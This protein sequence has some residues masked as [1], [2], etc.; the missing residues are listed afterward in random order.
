MAGQLTNQGE[1]EQVEGQEVEGGQEEGE[2]RE[3]G[4]EHFMGS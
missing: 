4:E 3:E 2:G 1:I